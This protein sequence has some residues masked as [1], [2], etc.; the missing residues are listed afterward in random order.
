MWH[1]SKWNSLFLLGI[2]KQVGK[3]FVCG[4]P[5]AIKNFEAMLVT[6]AIP[7]RAPASLWSR[8]TSHS[9]ERQ[10][11][12]REMQVARCLTGTFLPCSVE[13][14]LG[15]RLPLGEGRTLGSRPRF[16]SNYTAIVIRV[17]YFSESQFLVY[18]MLIISTFF[19]R[20]F[21]GYIWNVTLFL[22][23]FPCVSHRLV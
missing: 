17:L 23:L 8:W 13:A 20:A 5:P 3:F 9:V 21:V 19:S 6:G 14:Q 12:A 4:W 15:E 2:T 10:R 7:R 16:V 1:S 18:H 11:E 22:D